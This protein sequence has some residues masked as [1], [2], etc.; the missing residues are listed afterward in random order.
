[1][2]HACC[3]FCCSRSQSVLTQCHDLCHL[4]IYPE[5]RTHHLLVTWCNKF[6][7]ALDWHA[8]GLRVHAES[9]WHAEK[10]NV[11]TAWLH[12]CAQT[13]W[14]LQVC[15]SLLLLQDGGSIEDFINSTCAPSSPTKVI[16]HSDPAEE[17]PLSREG[18]GQIRLS[19]PLLTDL[20]QRP[21][22]RRRTA[23]SAKAA[24]SHGS[25]VPA[26]IGNAT[27]ADADSPRQ[28]S[29]AN[30]IDHIFQFHKVSL[31][32]LHTAPS[33]HAESVLSGIVSVCC[34]SV[35]H[36]ALKGLIRPDWPKC[37]SCFSVPLYPT[38]L[39]QNPLCSIC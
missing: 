18:S 20:V 15:D 4:A 22:K 14:L 38:P 30:P 9:L 34:G 23:S 31:Q 16:N 29:L 21:L 11:F 39:P 35:M 36:R 37:F 10:C 33:L 32:C 1:M 5:S 24:G 12:T 25:H 6:S 19:R 2:T 17:P 27:G 26:A 3:A 7:P 13:L 28:Q 8:Q